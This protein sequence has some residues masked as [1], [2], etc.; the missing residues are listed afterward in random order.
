MKGKNDISTQ[1][2]GVSA[3]FLADVKPQVDGCNGIKYN[4]TSEI[5]E[6]IFNTYPAVKRKHFE[7]VPHKLSEQ[8]FW[9]RF[10][11][12]HY[13][14]RDRNTSNKD[15]FNDCAKNDE[16]DIERAL[17]KGIAV[18]FV[19]LSTF[20]D[21]VID[22]VFSSVNNSDDIN[23]NH[24]KSDSLNSL[25]SAN[26]ALIKRFNHH[27]IMVLDACLNKSH[28][29]LPVLNGQLNK[30]SKSSQPTTIITPVIDDNE[31]IEAQQQRERIKKSRLIEKTEFADLEDSD[32]QK[33]KIPALK[34]TNQDRYLVG[35]IPNGDCDIYNNSY[36][37]DSRNNNSNNVLQSYF[38]IDHLMNNW[39]PRCKNALQ[40]ASAITAL[41]ELSPGGALMK[42]SHAI[43]LKDEVPL[44]VQKELKNL[45]FALNELLRH[46][47]S[48]FPATTPQIEEK[49]IQ[50]RSTLERFQY[51]K[52]QPFHDKLAREY[53]TSYDVSLIKSYSKTSSTC[54]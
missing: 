35:P 53:H 24:N 47:W 30:K 46:F 21:E 23:N 27:S 49:L 33:V 50:M 48:C 22:G 43:N 15:F 44:D 19:D 45:S 9:Q 38:Q 20:E 14:H 42:T 39:R 28:D 2:V 1:S 31:I 5:I 26:E 13:F 29:T 25:S 7:N 18:P 51:A 37:Y 11:Q 32:S 16:K 17:R 8:E 36:S 34:I 10:F 12:S 54:R 52:L 3:A 40:S 41:S 6:A 4:I